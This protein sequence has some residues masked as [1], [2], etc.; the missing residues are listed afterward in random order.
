MRASF[1]LLLVATVARAS[2]LPQAMRDFDAGDYEKV[3][4]ELV[5][6][7]QIA[8]PV[9]RA[10]ALRLYGIA[11][12]LTGR[13]PAAEDAFVRWLELAPRARLDPQLVRPDVVTFFNAV[14]EHHRAQLLAEVE[15]RRPRSAAL[16]LLP[17][18]G[19]F[20]NGQRAK[21]GVLLAVELGLLA[22][23]VAT[24]VALYATADPHDVFPDPGRALQLKV[25]NWVSFFALGATLVYGIVDGFVIYRRIRE[26]L[27]RDA[28]SLRADLATVRF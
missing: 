4:R 10:Q 1:A 19:Q 2:P 12:A 8:D 28:D 26:N 25:V 6:A 13:A 15:R 18:A 16:N 24:G 21:F 22:I 27:R 11:C 17:P 3:V 14:R 9:D 7:P 23:N 20:Q 5:D